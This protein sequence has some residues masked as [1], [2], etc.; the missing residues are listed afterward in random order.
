M[1]TIPLN[2]MPRLR[3]SGAIPVRPVYAFVAIYLFYLQLAIKIKLKL[4]VVF[5]KFFAARLAM[6]SLANSR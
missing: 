6:L 4:L 1:L 3:M 2:L 5:I